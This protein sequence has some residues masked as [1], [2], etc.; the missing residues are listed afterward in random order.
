MLDCIV[1]KY[2]INIYSMLKHGS[3]AVIT[4]LG[5]RIL[6]GIKNIMLAFPIALTSTVL[7]RQN[8]QIKTFNK[9]L[10]II[11]IDLIIVIASFISTQ[12][13]FIG[14]IINITV[15]FLIMYIIFS[16]YDLTFYKPF[17]ML[18]VFTQYS[19]ITL[20]ELPLRILA[21]IFGILVIVSSNI[22]IKVNEVNK[23]GKS[24]TNSISLIN[25]QLNNILN[26]NFEES[27]I[28]ECSKIMRELAYSIYITR[29]KNYLTTHLGKIQFELYINIEYFNLFLRT[30]NELYKKEDIEKCEI[31][32]LIKI[33]EN[34]IQ[35]SNLYIS[36]EY[37][38]E[39]INYFI[40]KYKE[41]SEY[42]FEICE[43]LKELLKNFEE[44][45]AL[46]NKE[47]N[48]V[49]EEWEIINIDKNNKTSKEHLIYKGMRFNFAMRMSIA[50]T[51]GLTL[52]N[53]LGFY[54]IIWAVITIMSVIQP[55]YE[56]TISKT[57]ERIIGNIIGILITGIIINLVN[58]RF[59]TIIILIISLYL[60]YAF[61]EYY[62]I[63]LFASIASI[64][65]SSLSENIN[66]LLFYRVFY[67]IIGVTIV[68]LINRV[69][70]PYKLKEG[71]EELILKIDNL[72][73]ILINNSISIL[74]GKE[75]PNKIRDIIIHSTLLS[76][77]LAI[78][79]LNFNDEYIDRVVNI[80]NEFII[81]VGYRVLRSCN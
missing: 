4:M 60:L 74:D 17:L 76:E 41:K 72:N 49:Y 28:K 5:V 68:I 58:I 13:F 33:I 66:I 69:I 80:N 52:A 65:I 75:N 19:Y 39:S 30:I 55:Y 48:R 16:P 15:I 25:T 23:L 77:K 9:I 53:I 14:I 24:I 63:S 20:E 57:K 62:K 40:K 34:I 51:I 61:K 29:H 35:Y 71:I 45:N 26:Q 1:K 10:R 79:N 43:L 38:T 42:M 46:G 2:K 67:V 73:T 27:L 12:N 70:F 21:V 56:Y 32:E 54:K 31:K 50:V 81:Q 6:F 22:I 37:L 18:Y 36:I 78:R 44:L 8:L 11:V 64:C 3:V 7:G 47:I 59:I